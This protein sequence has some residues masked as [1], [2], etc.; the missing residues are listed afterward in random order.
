MKSHASH[1]SLSKRQ[2]A[3]AGNSAPREHKRPTGTY[4]RPRRLTA[5]FLV[6]TKER[7]CDAATGAHG[8]I[9]S[10]VMAEREGGVVVIDAAGTETRIC[11]IT[12]A[13]AC[14]GLST[15]SSTSASNGEGAGNYFVY[16]GAFTCIKTPFATASMMIRK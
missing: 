9:F 14:I 2:N 4:L 7:F 10:R 15:I 5:F 8:Y 16:A 1:S 6:V 3:S 11:S 12:F 13:R